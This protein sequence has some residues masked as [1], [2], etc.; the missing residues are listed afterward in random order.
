MAEKSNGMVILTTT[1]KEEDAEKLCTALLQKKLA[2]CTQ[3]IG[4]IKSRYW[5]EG[6]VETSTEFL[7]L[8]KTCRERYK[9]V[10]NEIKANHP[11]AVPEIV[12]IETAEVSEDYMKWLQMIVLGK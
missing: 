11:Y 3:I 1:E 10:E 6:K 8:I 12:A 9:E 7:C 2:G 5:W 4:P